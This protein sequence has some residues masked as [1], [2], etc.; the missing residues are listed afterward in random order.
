[1]SSDVRLIKSPISVAGLLLTTI[2]AVVFAV[3]LP[4]DLFSLHTNPYIAVAFLL[5]LVLLS[6]L[7]VLGL[8]MIPLGTWIERRRLSTAWVESGAAGRARRRGGAPRSAS[9]WPRY[10]FLLWRPLARP[11]GPGRLRRGPA[12]PRS[13][14]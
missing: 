3:A 1:M 12:R 4:A 6:G 8:V 14:P 10:R 5:M 11:H 13:L 7:F 2:C 9:P